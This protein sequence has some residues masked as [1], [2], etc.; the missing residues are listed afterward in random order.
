MCIHASWTSLP[1]NIRDSDSCINFLS[2]LKTHYFN[3]AIFITI[4]SVSI[5]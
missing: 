1:D 5:I 3:I 4:L 2:R